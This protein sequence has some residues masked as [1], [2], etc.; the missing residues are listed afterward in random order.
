MCSRSVCCIVEV[1]LPLFWSP[2]LANHEE[3]SFTVDEETSE[4]TLRRVCP[5]L[6]LPPPLLS[7]SSLL[8]LA[9]TFEMYASLSPVL[10]YHSPSPPAPPLASDGPSPAPPHVSDGPSPAPHVSD[11]PSPAPHASDGPSLAPPHVSDGPSPAP[12]VSDGPSPAP[13]ASD[14]PSPASHASDGP[15]PAPHASDGPSPIRKHHL[16]CVVLHSSVAT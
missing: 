5:L 9:Y 15:S 14:G 16:F 12:H 10:F 7:P 4:M 1:A 13:H 3:F 2:G 11:G 6:P 8:A